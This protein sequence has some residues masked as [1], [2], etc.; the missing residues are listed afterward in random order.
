MR[1]QYLDQL[2]HPG[3][4]PSHAPM[5]ASKLAL[6]ILKCLK[7]HSVSKQG[8]PSFDVRLQMRKQEFNRPSVEGFGTTQYDMNL[9]PPLFKV[10]E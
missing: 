7:T 9:A 2:R 6:L 1:L 10:F 3:E 8:N 5:V 4:A